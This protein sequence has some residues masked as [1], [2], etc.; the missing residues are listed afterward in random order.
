M[1]PAPGGPTGAKCVR[2]VTNRLSEGPGRD[3]KKVPIWTL[4]GARAR[5]PKSFK[6]CCLT[7]QKRHRKVVPEST[8][9]RRGTNVSNNSRKW[10][11]VKKGPV[12]PAARVFAK[13]GK[14]AKS[15][16]VLLK[17]KH[18]GIHPAIHRIQRKRCQHLLLGPSL[19]HTPGARMTVVKQTPSNYVCSIEFV[20]KTTCLS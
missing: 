2:V 16:G 11:G 17:N 6:T 20:C 7:P 5:P 9:K 8:T 1:G 18:F 10:G 3:P 13:R 4:L 15:D 14:V 12:F 19:P